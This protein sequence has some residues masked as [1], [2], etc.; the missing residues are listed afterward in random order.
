MQKDSFNTSIRIE[1]IDN[2]NR[3]G[4][5]G[6]HNLAQGIA[7]GFKTDRKIVRAMTFFKCLSL[8]RTKKH[9]SPFLPENNEL[10]FRPN[11]IFRL[12][13]YILA[14]GFRYIPFTQGDA[15]G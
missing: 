8:S 14:D 13:Y 10:Q 1:M 6:Q 7:L 2:E 12:E 4:L 11:K 5:K 15:L 9:E 3:N